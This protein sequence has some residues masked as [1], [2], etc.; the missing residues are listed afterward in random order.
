MKNK[1]LSEWITSHP[2]DISGNVLL[3]NNLEALATID[4]DALQKRFLKNLIQNY[5]LLEKKVDSLLKNILP[6]AVAEEL[7]IQGHFQPRPYNCTILFTDFVG[8][9][10]LSEVMEKTVLLETLD[11]IFTEFDINI[12]KFRGTKIKTVGDAYMAI[13]GAPIPCENH[14]RKAIQAAFAMLKSM[15]KFNSASQYPFHMRVGIHS[16]QVMGGVVGKER[17][18]FDVFGDDVNIASRFESSGKKDKINVSETTHRLAENYFKF[19]NRG[20][21][22]LKNKKKMHAYFAVGEK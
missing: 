7:K 12:N 10:A 3:E 13:F 4:D 2:D 18:Q 17:M 5:V 20:L 14:A 22:A 16:G 11:M 1:I 15:E 8:F 6:E 9:T 19:E 21:I